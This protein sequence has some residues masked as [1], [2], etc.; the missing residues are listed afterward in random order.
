MIFWGHLPLAAIHNARSACF[1]TTRYNGW[2]ALQV[3]KVVDSGFPGSHLWEYLS[4]LTSG[5]TC[6][7][8]LAGILV[9]ILVR[10]PLQEYLSEYL[11]SFFLQEYFRE[12]LWDLKFRNTYEVSHVA[13]LSRINVR[14][15]L[16]IERSNLQN[17]SWCLTLRC[18][19]EK[20]YKVSHKRLPVSNLQ[21][22]LW[23]LSHLL[24]YLPKYLWFS[25]SDI[26]PCRYTCLELVRSILLVYV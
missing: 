24:E 14:S 3:C 8:S 23:V 15:R 2:R 26:L 1:P 11:S 25:Y 16:Y 6:R 13:I 5:N 10:S 9:G 19:Y 17:F 22:Y 20:T 21:E 7:V 18:T 4:G 12:Y